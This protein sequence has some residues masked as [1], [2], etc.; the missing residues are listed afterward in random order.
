MTLQKDDI[1]GWAKKYALYR[2]VSTKNPRTHSP[3]SYFAF[4]NRALNHRSVQCEI[5]ATTLR[6]ILHG[7][8]H[9]FSNFKIEIEIFKILK[10]PAGYKKVPSYE[11]E[12]SKHPLNLVRLS[13]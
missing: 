1:A 13:L 7:E 10:L 4:T 12:L 11:I 6:M 2:H 5:S 9:Y 3:S 8:L